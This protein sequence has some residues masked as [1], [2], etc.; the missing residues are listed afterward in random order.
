[1]RTSDPAPLRGGISAFLPCH[2]EEGNVERVVAAVVRAL[3]V[4]QVP[5]EV[6]VVDDG[7]TD[8]TA[9]VARRLADSDPRVRLVQH[10]HNLGY[11]A[12]LR[13]GFSASRYP[14]IFFTDGD[15]QFDPQ[16]LVRL[17]PHASSADLVVG[18]RLRRQDPPHRRLVGWLWNLLVRAWFGVR[19]RDVD[20]A[21][22]LLRK[23]V[24]ESLPLRA[25]GAFL[26]TE[27]LCRAA[28]RGAR[29]VEVGVPHY[30]R[31]WGRQSG[32]R[33]DVVVRAFVELW[34]L[35]SEL[36]GARRDGGGTS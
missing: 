31:R 3:E 9:E 7:S 20:C 15:G 28:Q 4:L 29:I 26:S 32:G 2:N 12:A 27:L 17:L 11:G 34:R 25:T 14:W 21:F 1:M 22:K 33:L 23:E 16:D 8:G 19:V 30:P 5:F 6:I 35:R 24:V 36:R 10:P 13:T 18:Y